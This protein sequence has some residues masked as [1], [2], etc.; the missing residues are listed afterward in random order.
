MGG[1]A[2]LKYYLAEGLGTPQKFDITLPCWGQ[3]SLKRY[4]VDGWTYL[5]VKLNPA[6]LLDSP[7]TQ[8]CWTHL[9]LNPAELTSTNPADLLNL[10]QS[11]SC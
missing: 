4:L 6:E 2:Y 9:K 1:Q 8:S 3:V 5:K 11:Q 7:Q 10:S